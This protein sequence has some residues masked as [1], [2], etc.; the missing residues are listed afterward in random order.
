MVEERVPPA[1]FFMAQEE[2]LA[3]AYDQR[4]SKTAYRESMETEPASQP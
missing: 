1:D 4:G 3:R 2:L